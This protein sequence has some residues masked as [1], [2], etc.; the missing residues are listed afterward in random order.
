MIGLPLDQPQEFDVLFGRKRNNAGNKRV[1]QLV[2]ELATEYDQAS[3]ARKTQ[4]A[5]SVVHE[6][7]RQ[8]GRFMKQTEGD[9]DK[10]EEV[11]DDFA[12]NKISKHF[13][14]NRRPPTAKVS[15]S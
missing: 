1:R 14:N 13:R 3:K 2:G 9:P 15:V 8:G 5:D 10:W 7:H 12:R 6:I 11:P 4:I